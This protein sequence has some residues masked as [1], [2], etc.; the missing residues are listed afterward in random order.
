VFVGPARLGPNTVD[1][2]LTG[3]APG[4]GYGAAVVTAALSYPAGHR[5]PTPVTMTRTAAGQYQTQG[6]VLGNT[7]QWT[8][9]VT[10]RGAPGG[11]G[12]STVSFSFGVH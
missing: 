6:A 11:T 1:V 5:G 8:L 2:Y 4:R 12:A 3:A 10:V 9:T 7:G